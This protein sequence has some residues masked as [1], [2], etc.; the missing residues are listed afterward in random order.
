MTEIDTRRLFPSQVCFVVDDVPS[1][2]EDCARRFGWGPFEHFTARVP[3]ARYRDWTGLKITDVA[4]GMAGNV[5]VELIHVHEGRDSVATYQ[6]EYGTGFQHLGI[7]C[8]SRDI[9]ASHLQSLGAAV[10]DIYEYAA[11]RIAFIDVPTGPAMFELIERSGQDEAAAQPDLES[12]A[13]PEATEPTAVFALDRATIVTDDMDAAL[14]FYAAAFR[15][16]EVAADMQT[17][18]YGGRE[19]SLR[20]FLG[21][22]G[23]LQLELVEPECKA[24]DPYSE[25]LARGRHGLTH[26]GGLLSQDH[27]ADDPGSDYEWLET[28]ERFSLCDWAG[29][30]NALQ[31]R[32]ERRECP[33]D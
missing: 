2:A 8:R 21:R 25:H 5:Q 31:I 19:A 3:D 14:R 29:G 15:W 11:F 30:R 33:N 7:G 20:R 16:S 1:A 26:T 17:L 12:S 10:D 22:A 4:L 27:P 28:S 32:R 23:T 24:D 13:T 9:A 6:T 18:R